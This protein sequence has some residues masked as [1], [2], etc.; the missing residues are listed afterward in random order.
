MTNRLA[1]ATSPYLL[2]HA[3]NP[4]D[5][6]PWDAKALAQARDEDKPILLSV[7][8]AA[9]HW[10]H[11]MAHESFEDDTTAARMNADFVNIKVDREE[12]PD[13]D[14][15]YQQALAMFG[16]HGGW[17]LTM[18]LTPDGAPFFGGTYF[19]PE[20]RHGRP[21]FGEVLDA[22]QRIWA[23]ERDKALSNGRQL[24][25]A[26]Q[27]LE[28][29]QAGFDIS[30]ASATLVAQRL[31]DML[32]GVHGGIGQAPKFPQAPVMDFIWRIAQLRGD[33]HLH[34]GVVY[35]LNRMS[36]GGIYDHLGGGLA[37][38]SVDAA[39]LVPHFEKMLYDNGQ[40]LSALAKVYAETGDPLFAA[41]MRE[42]LGWL[43][44]EMQLEGGGLASSLDADSDGEEGKFYVWRAEEIDRLLAGDAERFKLA[45]GVRYSGNW[46]GSCIL[47]RLHSQGL[48]EPA[49]EE[50]LAAMRKRLFEAREQRVRPALDDKVLA[51]WNGLAITGIVDAALAL[52]D[53][54]WLDLAGQAYAFVVQEMADGDRLMHSW[55][56]AKRLEL[57]FLDDYAAMAMA[58]LSLYEATGGPRYLDDAKRWLAVLEADYASDSGAFRFTSNQASDVLIHAVTAH[59]GPTPSGNGLAAEACA[60]LYALTGD[61]SYRARVETI[62]RAFAGD[63]QRNGGG[64]GA[65]LS[66]SLV[67]NRPVQIVL[68]GDPASDATN[69]L[70]RVIDRSAWPDRIVLRLAPDAALP[71]G[72]PAAGKTGVDGKPTAYVC[73]GPV[74]RAPITDAA[75]LA[76]AL[77]PAALRTG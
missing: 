75:T 65:L 60:R 55:R 22:V 77:T 19:P 6:Q 10:C 66:A 21:S 37:R 5:W 43:Q 54:T 3:A 71:D 48:A 53:R 39:W 1:D 30:L 12:R 28:S 29:P 70:A 23:S 45:Y 69:A 20:R 63:V 64:Y 25:E 15:I 36:Q 59:D 40:Y 76:E 2:Q 38:Y 27:R 52:D 33:A 67:L 7:G 57:A 56:A 8:Y 47:H 50:A 49:D 61:A 16:E 72:H 4:V 34:Q 41:R 13:L 18:F 62:V 9:C 11:V 42:T 46:E 26:L 44:R 17:P 74:C 24:H 14:A 31:G 51:D 58:A 32:D 73:V 68:I 35:A